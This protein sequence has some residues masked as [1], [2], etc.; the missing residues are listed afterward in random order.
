MESYQSEPVRVYGISNLELLNHLRKEIFRDF[1]TVVAI[2][3]LSWALFIG[4]LAIEQ[5]CSKNKCEV[6]TPLQM[7]YPSKTQNKTLDTIVK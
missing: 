1:P 6:S 3:T 4:G 2:Y 7:I 5:Y